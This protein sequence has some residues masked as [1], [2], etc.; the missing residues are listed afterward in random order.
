MPVEY[1]GFTLK[2]NGFF[3]ENIAMNLPADT[4]RHS[5]DNR[6]PSSSEGGQTC[7]HGK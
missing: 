4:N 3:G 2:P 6:Q 7:C 1:A 5:I